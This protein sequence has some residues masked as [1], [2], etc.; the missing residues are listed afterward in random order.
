VFALRLFCVTF[1]NSLL[2]TLLSTPFLL[3]SPLLFTSLHSFSLFFTPL[4][5]TLLFTLLC[6][7]LL[8]PL[9]RQA[10]AANLAN[11]YHTMWHVQHAG[12]DK[13]FQAEDILYVKYEDLKNKNTRV[14]ALAKVRN[15][16]LRGEKPLDPALPAVQRQVGCAFALA[17]NPGAHRAIDPAKK[18]CPSPHI[19]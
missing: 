7:L 5:F 1:T 18:V 3:S 10:N 16:V 2:S 13:H 9:H 17:E 14:A 11:L 4:H 8:T 6:T 12:I 19:L 15:F